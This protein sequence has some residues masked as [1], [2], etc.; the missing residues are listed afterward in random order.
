MITPS[1]LPDEDSLVLPAAWTEVLHPRRGGAPVPTPAPD[2]AAIAEIRVLVEERGVPFDEVLGREG[3]DPEVAERVRAH[4]D[5]TADPLGAAGV[6]KILAWGLPRGEHDGWRARL[7]DAWV[8]EHGPVFAARALVEMFELETEWSTWSKR[9]TER[10]FVLRRVRPGDHL[11]KERSLRAACRRLRALLAAADEDVR[12]EVTD[13][14]AETRDTPLRRLVVSYLLPD[15]RDW[16]DECCAAPPSSPAEESA[17][18]MLWCS[19]GTADQLARMGGWADLGHEERELDVLATIADGAGAGMTSFVTAPLDEEYLPADVRDR[20]VDVLTR[21]PGDEAFRALVDRV[22]DRHVRLV[23]PKAAERFPVRA[24]RLLSAAARGTGRRAMFARSLL[25]ERVLAAPDATAAAL[26]ALP[27]E[28]RRTVEEVR[29][30]LVRAPEAPADALPDLLV[31]PPWERGRTTRPAVLT[32]LVPPAEPE[33]VWEDGERREWDERPDHRPPYSRGDWKAELARIREGREGWDSAYWVLP[34]AP[35]EAVRPLLKEWTPEYLWNTEGW[36]PDTVA[37]FQ[38]EALP[39]VL[40]VARAQ[41]AVSG[42]QLLPFRS[43]EV[44]RLMAD[45]LARL[46][47]VRPVALRW[48]VRHGTAAARLLVPD[49]LGKPGAQRRVAEGALVTLA[50]RT[51]AETVLAAAREYGDQA[52]AAIG[53][54]L[55]MDPLDRLPARVPKPGAWADPALLPRPLLRDRTTGLP[56][57]AT[58]HAVTMLAMS[59]LD[60]VY[61]GVDVLREVCDPASLAEFGWAVFERW[62]VVGAPSKDGWALTQLGLVGDDETVRRLTPFIRAWPG[63]GGHKRAV[64]GLDVLAAI[65]TDV[66]LMH[67]HGVAQKVKFK[68]LRTRAQEK[69]EEV[70]DRLGLTAEQLADRLV[71]DFGLD[72]GGSMVLDYGPRRFTVGFDEQLKPFVRDENGKLRKSLPKPGVK[73]DEALATAAYQRF[74]ALRKDVRTVA[75]DQIRRLESA[76]VRRRRWTAD[77][78][79]D[80]FVAHPLLRHLV[81]RLVWLAEDGNATTAFRV[82]EDGTFADVNDDPF[83]LPDAARIGIAHA[84]DLDGERGT[85]AD[86]LADYEIVQ[87][88]PQLGRPVHALAE[89][90]RDSGELSRF[91]GVTLPTGRVVGLERRGWQRGAPQD[92]GIQG[93]IFRPLPD[94]RYLVVHLDPGIVVGALDAISEQQL[95]SVVLGTRPDAVRGPGDS[96]PRFGDLDPVTASEILAELTELTES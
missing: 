27:D 23:L 35:K 41:P 73:D 59:P 56:A 46:R 13:R 47:S 38:V 76:M 91:A 89:G 62:Q 86:L 67:L 4:L 77:D 30:S 95:H 94:G 24:L 93:E 48:L 85:W 34:H 2:P 8:V 81:R 88:F 50:A 26:P 72:A 28:A 17:R 65:G 52:A 15:R 90:E 36:L 45:W 31:S 75:V 53:E 39:L 82:A 74:A 11:G 9:P 6:A 5:G 1:A 20:L 64:T 14:L 29:R 3:T 79:R 12:R 16:V 87:P 66:A 60:E 63:E 70:A 25:E 22:E 84:L 37:R 10:R 57:A 40:R 78:F 68:A 96:G 43:V 69:I 32:G 18:W 7:A 33:L 54:L 55:A 21:L 42:Q 51:D 49:A 80:L 92:A 61:P 71:P 44:A 83:T 58:R 19:V